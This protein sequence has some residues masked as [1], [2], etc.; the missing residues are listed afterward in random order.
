MNYNVG[1]LEN[2]QQN[3]ERL[4]ER[5]AASGGVARPKGSGE[6]QPLCLVTS[7]V[8]P[9]LRQAANTLSA[10]WAI[11]HVVQLG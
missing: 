3:A 9:R 5:F 7:V 1:N 10:I 4:T 8:N 11:Q 2:E 6:N